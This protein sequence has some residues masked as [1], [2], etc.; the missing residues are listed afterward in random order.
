[1]GDSATAM[2]DPVFYRWHAFVDDIFQEYKNLLPRYQVNQV[3]KT[4][5]QNMVVK[6][7]YA[8]VTRIVMR[9]MNYY[10]VQT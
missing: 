10:F 2:R 4:M 9:S 1:M 8:L 3:C 7:Q 6:R 5:V